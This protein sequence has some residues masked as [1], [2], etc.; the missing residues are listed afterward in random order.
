MDYLVERSLAAFISG[1]LLSLSGSFIQL[2]TR[3]ILASPS[4][5]GFDGLSV[6]WLLI[7]HSLVLLTVQELNLIT[8][9]LLGV[10]F[11]LVVGFYF[12]RFFKGEARFERVILVGLTFNLLVGAVFSLWQFFFLAFNIPFPMELWFGNFRFS[13]TSALLLLGVTLLGTFFGLRFYWRDLELYSLGSIAK[14]FSLRG[15]FIRYLYISV[16]II[17]FVIVALFGAFSFLA[18]IFPILS[19]SLWF[20]RFDLR[21]EFVFG[22]LLNG[23]LLMFT[24]LLCYYFPIY[25]AEVP[26]GL[27]VS[28]VGAVSLIALLWKQSSSESLAK[29]FK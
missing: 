23:A 14:G 25:G 18:L 26:V 9:I 8:L 21:G 7:V 4:T 16:A 12:S 29:P 3:N 2:G 11:F 17:T 20:K 1:T 13:N 28:I 27:L 19:R 5:L 15:G 22:S 10:P 24:D 6:L